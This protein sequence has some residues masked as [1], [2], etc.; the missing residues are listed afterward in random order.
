[1]PTGIH[2]RFHVELVRRAADDPLPSQIVEDPQPGPLLPDD[3]D[4][5]GDGDEE[6]AVE[7]ILR[8]ERARR[9]R[10][11]QRRALV[12]WVGYAAP[13]WEPLQEVEHTDAYGRFV[14]QFGDGDGVGEPVGAVIGRKKKENA[15]G[16][17]PLKGGGML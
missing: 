14:S 16:S 12:Q 4:R 11:W 6:Y 13:T 10:G 9:G 7:K 3:L 15:L 17:N 8:V 5:D 1:M 2:P